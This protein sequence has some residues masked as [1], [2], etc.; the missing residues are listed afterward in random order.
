VATATTW[1]K[2]GQAG[3]RL[4]HGAIWAEDMARAQAGRR[5]RRGARLGGGY[6]TGSCWAEATVR[7]HAGRRIRRGLMLGGGYGRGSGWAEDTVRAH[8]GRR[9]LFTPLPTHELK[10]HFTSLRRIP[11]ALRN[12]TEAIAAAC[13]DQDRTVAPRSAPSAS[14]WTTAG[15]RKG[16]ERGGDSGSGN[17]RQ[18]TWMRGGI[19]SF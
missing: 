18:K 15:A 2:R 14:G 9:N 12:L 7:A 10:R 13:L 8:A 5:L 1:Q 16:G 4:R 11:P 19:A 3:R 17:G 6:G